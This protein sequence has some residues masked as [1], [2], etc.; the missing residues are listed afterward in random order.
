MG[1]IFRRQ[2]AAVVLNGYFHIITLPTGVDFHLTPL[3]SIFARIL[4]QCIYHK[5]SQG[6]VRF[7]AGIGRLHFQIQPLHLESPVPFP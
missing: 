7:H 5:E 6:L 3:R 1:D 2:A 4:G